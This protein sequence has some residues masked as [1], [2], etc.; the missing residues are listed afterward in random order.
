M[1]A[2]AMPDTNESSC[3][4]SYPVPGDKRLCLWH[5]FLLAIAPRVWYNTRE[6]SLPM[7]L[8]RPVRLPPGG[9]FFTF[10]I[11]PHRLLPEA[12]PQAH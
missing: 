10:L 12:R 6:E 11:S 5:T 4:N 2:K 1:L 7:L 9:A 3:R 8:R